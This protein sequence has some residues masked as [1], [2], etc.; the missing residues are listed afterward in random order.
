MS[1]A[2]KTNNF[3][4]KAF[5]SQHTSLSLRKIAIALNLNYNMLLKQSKK[6]IEGVAYDANA[7]NFV[8]IDEYVNSRTNESTTND[9]DW[10]AI[11][12]EAIASKVVL[13]KEFALNENV[14]LRGDDDVYEI[15]LM[16]S[17]HIVLNPKASTQ[18][19]VMNLATF[20]HQGPRNVKND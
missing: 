1:N 17:T 8:A 10:D 2:V 14:S 5:L 20:L 7:T 13:P 11:E 18:P 9:I 12:S 16:T 15:V 4:S 19:R 6:P 3:D